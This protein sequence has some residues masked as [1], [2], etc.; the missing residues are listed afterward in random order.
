MADRSG[1]VL[2]PCGTAAAWNVE[3]RRPL[4]PPFNDDPCANPIQFLAQRTDLL[5]AAVKFAELGRC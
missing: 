5:G 2:G 3:L 4:Q 1:A